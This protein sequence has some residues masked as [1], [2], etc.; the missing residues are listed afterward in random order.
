MKFASVAT[1]ATVAL[2]GMAAATESSKCGSHHEPAPVSHP[3]KKPHH[4]P[5]H[6]H[7]PSVPGDGGDWPGK[8]GDEPGKGGD[9]PGKGGDWP[10]KGG[11]K[12]GKGG[13]KPG[14]G[15]DKPGKGGDKP[16]KGGDKP[17]K[18]GDKPGKGGDKPGKGGDKPGKGGDKPSK[19]GDNDDHCCIKKGSSKKDICSEFQRGG[20]IN[21]D[22]LGCSKTDISILSDLLGRQRFEKRNASTK[23]KDDGCVEKKEEKCSI[24]QS[25]ALINIDILG[26]SENNLD[27]LSPLL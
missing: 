3:H 21:L 22:L 26:C 1:L 16:G 17:G 10:G 4:H 11:D 19:G 24:Y 12:P 20:L 18:G 15:G 5:K 9:K 8:G 13:D 14:K 27:I 25:A 7:L 23:G 6:P 2:V